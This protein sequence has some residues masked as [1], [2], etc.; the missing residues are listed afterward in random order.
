MEA[1]GMKKSEIRRELQKQKIANWEAVYDGQFTPVRIPDNIVVQVN[2]AQRD[3]DGDMVPVNQLAQIR[4]EFQNMKL[5]EFLPEGEE[6]LGYKPKTLL[7]M[8]RSILDETSQLETPEQPV[9]AAV[10][11]PAAAQAG[12]APA[13]MAVPALNTANL[14]P[15]L[16][17]DNP[18]ERE[19]N[20]QIAQR[21]R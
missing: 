2:R 8:R 3:Y 10:P 21:T 16:L 14:D 4:N 13:Q 18:V 12:A 7:E 11:P 17:G 19:R 20:L 1:L 15:S 5:T 9:A 6:P